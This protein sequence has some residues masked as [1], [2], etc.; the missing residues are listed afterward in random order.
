MTYYILL[1]DDDPKN[2]IYESNIIGEDN[3]FGVFWAGQGFQVL[4]NIANNNIELLN[5]ITIKNDQN[6]TIPLDEFMK[7]LD[8]LQVRIQR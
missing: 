5:K 4:T 6:K 1:P 8:K 3:G 7:V 2:M